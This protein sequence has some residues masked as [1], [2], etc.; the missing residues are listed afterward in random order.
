MIQKENYIRWKNDSITQEL[1][2]VVRE[3]LGVLA[4][5]LINREEPNGTRDTLVRGIMKGMM[6]VTEWEPEFAPEESE[7]A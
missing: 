7:E 1:F 5:E 6:A 2:A 3:Q 4:A